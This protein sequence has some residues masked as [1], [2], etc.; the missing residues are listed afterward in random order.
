MT[1]QTPS[2]TIHQ[3][4]LEERPRE[5]L[6]RYGSRMLS[7]A[8][9]IA[10]VL[11]NGTRGTSVLQLAQNL[12]AHFGSIDQLAEATLSELC[13]VKGIGIAKAVQLQAVFGLGK[14]MLDK[15]ETVKVKIDN[16]WLVYQLLK[17]EFASQKQEH[18]IVVLQDV[19]G[20]L[21]CYEAVA[22]G[23]LTETLVHPREVFYPAIRNNAASI[24]I[25]HNHPSGDP[26]P[27]KEDIAVTEMLCEAGTLMNIPVL[28]HLI[29]TATRFISLRQHGLKCF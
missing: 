6:V 16:P 8:E 27:S 26:E 13:K 9:L 24:L 23:T 28:D 29:L 4:P 10:I 7:A 25:A 15:K 11:G 12:L 21:I 22:I 3:M 2:Y 14:R 17:E 18:F 20:C 1:L 19:R 5:R